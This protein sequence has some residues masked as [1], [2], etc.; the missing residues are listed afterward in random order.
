[1]VV[2]VGSFLT[3][4]KGI[5]TWWWVTFVGFLVLNF[6]CI[7]G[8]PLP[9]P[10]LFY[11]FYITQDSGWAD[12]ILTSESTFNSELGLWFF[13]SW[14]QCSKSWEHRKTRWKNLPLALFFGRVCMKLELLIPGTSALTWFIV[15]GLRS[16]CLLCWFMCVFVSVYSAEGGA[17]TALTTNWIFKVFMR[18]LDFYVLLNHLR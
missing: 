2:V 3:E 5:L 7:P 11:L 6:S 12:S 13:F 16:F 9:D 17:G 10:D 15:W 18:L 1:M 4:A 8:H 14:C